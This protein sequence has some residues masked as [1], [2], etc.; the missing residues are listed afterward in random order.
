MDSAPAAA[1]PECRRFLRIEPLDTLFFRDARPFGQKSHGVSGLPKPQTV[2]GALRTALLREAGISLEKVSAAVRADSTFRG[3]AETAGGEIGA[4]IGSVR[5]AGPW[6]GR[7]GS[8]LFPVPANLRRIASRQTAGSGAIVRLDP[9][10]EDLPGWNPPR[11]GMKPLWHR[12]REPSRKVEGYLTGDGMTRFL[13]GETPDEDEIVPAADLYEY[14]DRTGIAVDPARATAA[15]GMIYATR[16]LALCPGV[17]LYAEVRG[18]TAALDLFPPSGTV[19]ALGGEGRRAAVTPEGDLPNWPRFHPHGDG[20]LLILTTPALFGGWG[21]QGAKLL[22]AAVA[23]H[24]AVSG[25][26]LAR[27]GP[28]PN[29]FAVPAGSVYFLQPGSAAPA[30]GGLGAPEDAALGWGSYLQGSWKH[31]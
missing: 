22:A 25:W 5:F 18:P 9:L 13:K 4:D 20:A 21:P 12:G 2:A 3:A 29:R 27:G 11:S 30:S 1:P 28:K 8:A 7:G 24:E 19:I 26:D 23:G 10:P 17:C 6:F 16:M 31:A 15:A 14:D